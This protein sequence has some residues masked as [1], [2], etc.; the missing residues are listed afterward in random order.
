MRKRLKK[1]AGDRPAGFYFKANDAI[2]VVDQQA[3]APGAWNGERGVFLNRSAHIASSE[4]PNLLCY[5]R[6]TTVNRI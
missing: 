4:Y 5:A 6:G 3:L 2:S 1:P